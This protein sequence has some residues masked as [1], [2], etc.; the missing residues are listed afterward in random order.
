LNI[1]HLWRLWHEYNI[2]RKDTPTGCM[3]AT[4]SEPQS[5]TTKRPHVI[6]SNNDLSLCG[7]NTSA[8]TSQIS[9]RSEGQQTRPA[10]QPCT[11]HAGRP[12][13][14][15]VVDTP[16]RRLR[17]RRSFLDSGTDGMKHRD[18]MSANLRGCDSIRDR[19]TPHSPPCK[20]SFTCKAHFTTIPTDSVEFNHTRRG[21]QEIT[22]H[23]LTVIT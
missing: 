21:L 18:A 14:A 13:M 2:S 8:W 11:R 5:S 6:T 12:S 20:A 15:A 23:P 4:T 9:L 22:D 7:W 16:S 1:I 17:R 3:C 19:E 10:S